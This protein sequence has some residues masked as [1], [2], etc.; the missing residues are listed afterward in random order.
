[1]T[2]GKPYLVGERGPELFVPGMTGR[3]ETN[4]TPRRLTAD[5]AAAVAGSTTT[6]TRG[7]TTITNNWTINGA[8]DPRGVARQIDSRFGELLRQLEG[9][10]RGLLSD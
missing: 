1:V 7:P 8:D 10:Q 6:T 9:E 2:Y 4:N 5:G 3:V